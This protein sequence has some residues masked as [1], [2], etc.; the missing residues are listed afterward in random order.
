MLKDE[1]QCFYNVYQCLN[2][3]AIVSLMVSQCLKADTI[4]SIT[5]SLCLKVGATFSR[6]L[7]A[8]TLK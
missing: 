2:A 3:D 5:F 4:D 6:T 7:H 8:L 1:H